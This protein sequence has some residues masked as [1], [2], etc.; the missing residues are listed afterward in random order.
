MM[1]E[2]GRIEIDGKEVPVY[3]DGMMDGSK[4]IVIYTSPVLANGPFEYNACP[5]ILGTKP[6]KDREH[7]SCIICKETDDMGLMMKKIKE[8]IINEIPLRT[9]KNQDILP[10]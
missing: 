4:F 5:S 2:I 1:K 9:W 7:I 6:V 3:N 10:A 8:H